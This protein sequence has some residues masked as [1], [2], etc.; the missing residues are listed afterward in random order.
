MFGA[1]NLPNLCDKKKKIPHFLFKNE[2]FSLQAHYT[3]DFALKKIER[4]RLQT[5]LALEKTNA[6]LEKTRLALGKTSAAI[7]FSR[8]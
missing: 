2:E 6:A 7:E 4:M 8:L 3:P 5:R 1:A